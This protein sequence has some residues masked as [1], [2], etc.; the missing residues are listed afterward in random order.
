M[1]TISEDKS[2]VFYSSW[3]RN[4]DRVFD[5]MQEKYEYSKAIQDYGISGTVYQGTDKRMIGMLGLIY[6]EIDAAKEKRKNGS[7]GGRPKKAETEKPLVLDSKN[8]PIKDV[9]GDVDVDVDVSSSLP[10]RGR[11]KKNKKD[12]KENKDSTVAVSVSPSAPEAAA[13][14]TEIDEDGNVVEW[15]DFSKPEEGN[16]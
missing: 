7:K 13:H 10:Y 8:H 6:D 1:I 12:I 3:L 9:D 4:V 11:E 15:Y 2:F 16:D 5:T 14:G